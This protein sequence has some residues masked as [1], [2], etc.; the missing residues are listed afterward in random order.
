MTFTSWA[1][2]AIRTRSAWRSSVMSRHPTTSASVMSCVVFGQGRR[3]PERTARVLALAVLGQVPDVPFVDAQ[4]D[5]L[6]ALLAAGDAIRDAGHG[7]D[8]PVE[9]A[10]AREVRLGRGVCGGVDVA[11]QRDVVG[12]VPGEV[13]D[14]LLPRAE[15]GHAGSG[16]PARH[17]LDRGVHET[18]DLAGLGRQ[19]AV[20]DRRLAADLPR[21]VHLV[22]EA[23]GPDAMWLTVTV[24]RSAIREARAGRRSCSTRRGPG[25]PRSR[26]C[27]G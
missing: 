14:R 4:A 26:A 1:R 12:H 6:V 18:H 21:A 16:A 5:A 25:P 11:V 24:G 9:L 8:H 22:A 17:E 13:E 7:P 23:P 3:P 27:R 20:L 19:P 10:R 2:H 15:R